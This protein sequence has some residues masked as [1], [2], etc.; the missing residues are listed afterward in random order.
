MKK[1][2]CIICGKPLNDGIIINGS[3][4]CKNCEHRILGTNA[5]TDFYTYY[6]QCIKRTIAQSL[7]KGEDINCQNYHL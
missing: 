4:I 3:G 7:I 5:E 6:I 2:D 1:H